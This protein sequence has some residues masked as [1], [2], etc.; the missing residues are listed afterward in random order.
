MKSNLNNLNLQKQMPKNFGMN[1][2][3]FATKILIGIW[4]IPYL[5]KYIG[6]AAYGLVPLAMIFSQYVSLIVQ[7]LN[8]SISR[9]LLIALQKNDY[10]KANI[11]FNTSLSMI[12]V[13]IF[14]QS[15]FMIYII[16]NL[17]DIINIPEG[18]SNDAFWLFT[19]TFFDFSI[20]LLRSV[21]SAPLFA[22]NRLDLLRLIDIIQISSRAFIIVLIFTIHNPQLMYIGIANLFSAIIAFVVAFYFG[23]K[24]TP[25][26][27]IDFTNID[28]KQMKE[29]SSMSGWVLI[30][31]VGFLLFLKVDL[32]IANK[33]IGSTQ[34]GEYAA[35]LQWN[36]ILRTVAGVFSGIISPVIMIYYARNE[37]D[38]L[39][40]ML[41]IGVKLMGVIMAI[42]IGILSALS[43]DI[44]ALWLG[45]EFRHLGMLMTIS[46]VPLIINLS[47]MPLFSVNTSFNRVK[48]PG[49]VSLSLGFVNFILALFLVLYMKMDLYG[50]VISGAIVLT[51]KNAIFTP[52]YAAHVLGTKKNMF[53]GYQII[54]IVYFIFIFL[55]TKFLSII[56]LPNSVLSLLLLILASSLVS[57]FILFIYISKDKDMI[58][59]VDNVI[60]KIKK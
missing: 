55:L 27:K 14:I 26:L 4:I 10:V 43:E 54:S 35:V 9:F 12:L 59:L 42:P 19:L 41:K 28:L 15:L 51:F 2:L 47:V 21:I 18:L 11:I 39:I 57:I 50:L 38:K 48:V 40:S 46:L 5:I 22:H 45:E 56:I 29:V 34:A 6:I 13:F 30:N 17:A 33:F 60:K 44:L 31:Q 49:L 36:N 3:S 25:Q 1:I 52:M 53:F 7:S 24:I 8:T 37:I 16:N 58:P 23:K 20:S 32:F